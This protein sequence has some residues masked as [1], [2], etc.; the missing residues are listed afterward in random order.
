MFKPQRYIPFFV[1]FLVAFCSCRKEETRWEVEALA[2]IA[3][4]S[5]GMNDLVPDSLLELDADGLWHIH[6]EKNLTDFDIDTLVDIPETAFNLRY[7]LPISG[8]PFNIPPGTTVLNTDRENV[9][10]IANASLK[11]VRLES[12]RLEYTVRS[13]IN[14]ELE[15]KLTVPGLTVNGIPTTIS[16]LTSTASPSQTGSID[17][18]GYD[19]VLTGE[20]GNLTNRLYSQLLVK[21]AANAS[22]PAIVNAQDSIVVSMVFMDPVIQYA[23]GYFGQHTYTLNEYVQANSALGLPSGTLLLDDLQ[24]NFRIENYVGADAR[25]RLSE[26]S[27][28]H[29]ANGFSVPLDNNEIYQTFNIA[30]ATD[31]DGTVIPVVREVAMNG[32]NSNL[33]SFAENLP[34]EFAIQGEVIINPLGNVNNNNDFLY[35]SQP[36]NVLLDID[37]PLKFAASELV[38]RDTLNWGGMGTEVSSEG[39][40]YLQVENGFPFTADVELRLHDASGVYH[41]TLNTSAPLAAGVFT[42]TG[43]STSAT[44]SIIEVPFSSEQWSLLDQE[45]LIEL[46]VSF[47]T[48]NFPEFVGMYEDYQMNYVLSARANAPISFE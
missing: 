30:R 32:Q 26:L 19:V 43:H 35:T 36:L 17:L 27:G 21:V 9:F 42:G 40:L 33:T 18:A 10:N 45:C 38:I 14:G 31:V 11:R 8:G 5:L 41:G 15:S 3:R 16:A 44:Y 23:Q 4:G 22:A 12:G 13:Y 46:V 2:G 28:I 25:I 24:M 47:S 39:V 48:A 6:I 20:N 1:L 34:D 37:L 29:A 7:V